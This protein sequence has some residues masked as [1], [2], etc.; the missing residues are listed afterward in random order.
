MPNPK[1]PG[2][3]QD[4]RIA[5]SLVNQLWSHTRLQQHSFVHI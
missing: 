2:L 5:L 1:M 4:R 3:Q